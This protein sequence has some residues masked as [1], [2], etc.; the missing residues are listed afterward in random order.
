MTQARML[1]QD[2]STET[3]MAVQERVRQRPEAEVA[4]DLAS[5]VKKAG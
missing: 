1:G 5:D 4:W 2:T 3:G